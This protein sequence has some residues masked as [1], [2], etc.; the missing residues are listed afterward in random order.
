M[1]PAQEPDDLELLTDFL[2]IVPVGLMRFH[3]NGLVDLA[4]PKVAQLLTPLVP[5]GDLS[6]AYHA[7][8]P[9]A[10]D[11]A[12]R[13]NDATIDSGIV[14]DHERYTVMAGK[15]RA[16]LSLTVH[17]V[18]QISFI[19][20]IEDVTAQAE[21]E[22]QLRE[23][24][25]DLTWRRHYDTLTGLPNRSLLEIR[26]A[27]AVAE[28]GETPVLLF[29]DIMGTKAVN[30]TKGYAEGD[31]LLVEIA[32]RL[33]AVAG[34][35][36]LVARL[37][38]EHFVVLCRWLDETA[39]GDLGSRL[40]EA[41]AAPFEIDG[42]PF[43]VSTLVALANVDQRTNFDVLKAAD[44]AMQRAKLELQA[45]QDAERQRQKMEALGRM[46]GGVA[47]EINNMLQPIGL[48]VQDMIESKL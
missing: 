5:D 34:P 30:D 39:A 16:D 3:M 33:V 27:E 11:L 42:D 7:L 2:Y 26:L 8:A 23:T 40:R 31:A 35:D 20:V 37:G 13:L 44:A 25:A 47:H 43:H 48:L 29:L 28:G 19:A 46:M 1:D 17:R 41:I 12:R 9:V 21:Q 36:N 32:R 38:G 22:R 18:D 6:N 15:H 10:P 4:N 14:V 45:Q 24:K